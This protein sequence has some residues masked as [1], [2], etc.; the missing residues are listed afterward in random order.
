MELSFP[1]IFLIVT[2]AFLVMGPKEMVRVAHRCG[3]W[4]G[5]IRTQTNNMKIM[6][7]EEAMK[8]PDKKDG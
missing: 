1:E 5:K 3:L 8:E 2:I 6:L 7:T 4:L